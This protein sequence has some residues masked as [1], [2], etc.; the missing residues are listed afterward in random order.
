MSLKK[1][2]IVMALSN[3]GLWAAWVL[4]LYNLDPKES[5]RM[6]LVL[7]YASLFLALAGTFSLLGFFVRSLFFRQTPLFKHLN[8]SH[9]QGFLLSAVVTASLLLQ[10]AR[11]FAWWN[12]FI[13]LAMATGVEYLVVSRQRL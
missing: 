13:L 8:V 9:R 5:G 1:Y 2:L 11:L 12:G 4:V 10:A 7:F 6:A 3:A